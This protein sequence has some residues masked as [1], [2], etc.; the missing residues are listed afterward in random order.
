MPPLATSPTES[1]RCS[2]NREAAQGINATK[3]IE[4]VAA[5]N[6]R[7]TISEA[8]VDAAAARV[9]AAGLWQNPTIAY[10]REEVFEAGQ[11]VPENFIRLEL[12]FR[13]LADAL[14]SSTAPRKA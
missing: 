2:I 9:R 12:P 10:D 6:P 5:N 4:R 14:C 7:L 11:G 1:N 8:D 13:F 3:F